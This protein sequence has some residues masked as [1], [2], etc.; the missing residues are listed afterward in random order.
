MDDSESPLPTLQL[1][2]NSVSNS[3]KG[4]NKTKQLLR[5]INDII[6]EHCGLFSREPDCELAL[7]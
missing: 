3:V 6:E 5:D 1:V 2:T 7:V 4:S